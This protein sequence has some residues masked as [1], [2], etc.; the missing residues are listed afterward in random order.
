MIVGIGNDLVEI[1]RLE[2]VLDKAHGPRFVQ[3][4]FT[5]KEQN[6]CEERGALQKP[7]CYAK[8]FAAKEAVIKALGVGFRDGL[9]LTDIEILPNEWGK[10]CVTLHAATATWVSKHHPHGLAIHIALSDE[11][12]MAMATAVVEAG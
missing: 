1:K 6:L 10:P 8:R 4:S 11:K 7:A 3:R 5:E 12:G 9:W 2:R